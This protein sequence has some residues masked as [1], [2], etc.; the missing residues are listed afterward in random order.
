MLRNL[1]PLLGY[2]L[3]ASDGPAGVL[4]DIL[5]DDVSWRARHLVA[6]TGHLFLGHN[7]LLP[8]SS[9]S[10]IDW[11]HRAISIDMT[12]E[13]VEKS[14]TAGADEP[15][16]RQFEGQV[17][18]FDQWVTHSMPFGTIPEPRWALEFTG[19][20]HLRSV[21]HLLGYGLEASDG[22]AGRV[23]DFV[24]DSLDWRIMFLVVRTGHRSACRDVVLPADV[25]S[26]FDWQN[27]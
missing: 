14:P 4:R 9:I 24:A 13:A 15:I 18:N 22:H 25:V 5:F 27:R 19:D 26:S 3:R 20:E 21:A 17:L 10:D 12:K 6:H 23:Q 7:R 11:V 16:Y 1:R 8:P 2:R